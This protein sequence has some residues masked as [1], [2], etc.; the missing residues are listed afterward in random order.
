MTERRGDIHAAVAFGRTQIGKPY[1]HAESPQRFGLDKYDCSGFV[2]RCLWEG[3]MPRGFLGFG[4]S[5]NWMAMWAHSHPEMRLPLSAANTVFGAIIVYGGTGGAGP[6][7]HVVIG[8]ANGTCINSDGGHGVEIV[9]LSRYTH[10]DGGI[11][12]VLFA[13]INYAGVPAPKPLP[14][15]DDVFR[16]LNEVETN[17]LWLTNWLERRKVGSVQEAAALIQAGITQGAPVVAWPQPYIEAIPIA[18]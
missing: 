9:P 8:L 15:E 16:I 1:D 17:T 5:S 18:D 2:S 3:G 7:G 13:P 6:A 4:E 14:V 11:S 10:A 12:D